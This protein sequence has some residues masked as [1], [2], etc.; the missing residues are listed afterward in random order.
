MTKIGAFVEIQSMVKIGSK[1]KISSHTFICSGV[2]IEDEVFIG[3]GVMFTNDKYPHACNANGSLKSGN[4][5][6]M[7]HTF[8]RKGASI[9]SG[10]VILP[11][12]EIGEGATIGAGAVVTKNVRAHTT[13]IGNPAKDLKREKT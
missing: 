6:V 4:D 5:Y 13:V 3:H 11:G 2:Q 8:V 7:E 1:C 10:A 12:I 9:G